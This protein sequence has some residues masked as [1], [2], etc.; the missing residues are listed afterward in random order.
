MEPVEAALGAPD[1]VAAPPFVN[2]VLSQPCAHVLCP[3][4]G[5]GN[6]LNA[7]K[8]TPAAPAIASGKHSPLLVLGMFGSGTNMMT[9]ILRK[10]FGHDIVRVEGPCRDPKDRKLI[11]ASVHCEKF[12]KHTHPLRIEGYGEGDTGSAPTRF[13]MMVRNPVAQLASWKRTPFNLHQCTD[14]WQRCHCVE[15]CRTAPKYCLNDRYFGCGNV[16]DD[17][18]GN[19]TLNYVTDPTS[20]ALRAADVPSSHYDNHMDV[21]NSYVRGYMV[22]QD[23]VRPPV[24]PAFVVRYEDAVQR[25]LEVVTQLATH[26]GLPVPIQ[27]PLVEENSRAFDSSSVGRRKA[28]QRIRERDHQRIF[29]AAQ[30]TKICGELNG[31]LLQMLSYS[32]ECEDIVPHAREGI[33]ASRAETR[34]PSRRGGAR[35]RKKSRKALAPK[36]VRKSQR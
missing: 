14:M 31:T 33:K 11:G 30:R 7:S 34:M 18:G 27:T 24:P 13:V 5:G 35:S 6:A 26:F 15:R 28:L 23:T 10:S 17:A 1:A 12:W 8:S 4:A 22:L 25:P 2:A 29:T 21:W 9:A 20:T 36:P 19:V 32:A 16:A 3:G